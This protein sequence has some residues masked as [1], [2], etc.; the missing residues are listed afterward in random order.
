M[1]S[2]T[3][4]LDAWIA[5]PSVWH[6]KELQE[7]VALALLDSS[8]TGVLALIHVRVAHTEMEIPAQNAIFHVTSAKEAQL[9]A[10]H[11]PMAFPEKD[12]IV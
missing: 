4:I 2:I 7:T 8:V 11:V 10:K 1:E 12:N 5:M 6:V 3:K 9:D